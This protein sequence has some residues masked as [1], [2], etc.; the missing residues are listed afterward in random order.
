MSTESHPW[1]SSVVSS[2]QVILGTVT[3]IF[4]HFLL[5]LVRGWMDYLVVWEEEYKMTNQV[6]KEVHMWAKELAQGLTNF[7]P[8][9]AF[10]ICLSLTEKY[11]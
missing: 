2:S 8:A 9:I 10:H 4:S 5:L 11:S 1:H 3:V 7:V 6:I